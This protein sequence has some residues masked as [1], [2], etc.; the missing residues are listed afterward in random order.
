MKVV[1]S[2]EEQPMEFV[3]KEYAMLSKKSISCNFTTAC[4]KENYQKNRYSNVLA[5]EDT[6]VHIPSP[7]AQ[8]SSD[9]I[10]A[11]YVSFPRKEENEEDEL[12]FI[13]TQS[14]LIRTCEEFWYMIWNQ[15]CYVICALNRLI[16][17]KM[18]KG[19]RYWPDK[20][21]KIQFGAIS[22]TLLSTLKMK[23]LHITIRKLRLS[24]NKTHKKLYHLHYRGWPDFGVPDSTLPIRELVNLSMHYQK[25]GYAIGMQGPVVVHCSAGIG[26]SGAF[27]TIAAVMSD[28]KFKKMVN[29]NLIA[30]HQDS[31]EN[32]HGENINSLI[33]QFNISDLVLLIRKQRH[34]GTV[35]TEEQ[36]SF[37]YATLCDELNNPTLLSSALCSALNW[38]T[39]LKS[40]RM[41]LRRSGP[42]HSSKTTPKHIYEKLELPSLR[43]AVNNLP[44]LHRQILIDEDSP[45][46]NSPNTQ[47]DDNN[48]EYLCKSGLI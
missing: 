30:K 14:P 17:N 13:C 21:R 42:V 41:I 39:K 23:H 38:N 9:Y 2:Y 7:G 4:M 31:S 37:I 25:Q 43:D 16:E 40:S 29:S 8:K 15:N 26:R 18:V 32:N 5:L 19:D 34:P 48:R 27:M 10:N 35:Q 36:Y 45:K 46:C 24:Y 11:N 44:F 12:K 3:R 28:P 20:E 6:R 1:K 33:S 47:Q 22:I